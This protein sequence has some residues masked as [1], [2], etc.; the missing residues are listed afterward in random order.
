MPELI[1]GLANHDTVVFEAERLLY[2]KKY[3][4]QQRNE[5]SCVKDKLSEKTA[6]KEVA[7]QILNVLNG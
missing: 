5:L 7:E 3:S 6:Y 4:Q 1:Q 2:D